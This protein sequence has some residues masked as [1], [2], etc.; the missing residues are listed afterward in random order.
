MARSKQAKATTAQKKPA[1]GSKQRVHLIANAHLDPVWLWP[2]E[3]GLTEG[4][5]T[6]RIAADFCEQE[7]DFVFNH[8]E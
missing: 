5:S 4:L 3:D 8:N 1:Q 2:W 7:P 6:Y